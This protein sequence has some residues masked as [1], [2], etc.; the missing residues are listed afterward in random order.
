MTNLEILMMD[1]CTKA[2]AE[3][4]LKNG[5]V[6]FDGD[7]FEKHFESYMDEWDIEGGEKEEYR[8]MI[9]NKKPITD[10]GIVEHEEKTWYIMYVL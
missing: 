6:V 9:D 4:H 1:R 2:E 5:S 8:Q 3:K 7:D 10:W